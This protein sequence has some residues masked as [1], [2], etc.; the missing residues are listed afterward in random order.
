MGRRAQHVSS[1]CG[2]RVVHFTGKLA[3]TRRRRI[4][5]CAALLLPAET[6]LELAVVVAATW[7]K[8]K[9]AAAAAEFTL[10]ICN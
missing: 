9:G 2:R 5:H 7:T 10:T 1:S 4:A 6:E 3:A 8:G